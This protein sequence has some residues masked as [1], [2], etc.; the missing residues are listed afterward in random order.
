[1]TSNIILTAGMAK[2]M[3]ELAPDGCKALVE[4][5]G[6][7]M[8]EWQL[9][10]LGEATI[11]C[12]SQHARRLARYG[13]VVP[14]DTTRG[15]AF[16]LDAALGSRV[17]GPVTVVYADSFFDVLPSGDEWCGIGFGHGGRS[18]D[19]IK[20]NTIVYEEVPEGREAL[21][22]VGVYRFGDPWRLVR[23]VVTICSGCTNVAGMPPVLSGYPVPHVII[24]SWQDVG[25]PEALAA[26]S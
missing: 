19:V 14:D 24:P 13:R 26:V 8:I 9:D 18:W 11:V 3:G 25:T 2:R 1:M 4:F 21:V 6:R 7:P 16:A 5:R 22:C 12:R 17:D 15:P 10:V 23:R 20:G